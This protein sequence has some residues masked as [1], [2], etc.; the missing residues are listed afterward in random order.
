MGQPPAQGLEEP[1][2][3]RHAK[4]TAP[5]PAIV[6]LAVGPGHDIRG[7]CWTPD[8]LRAEGNLGLAGWPARA[9]E[10]G[11]RRSAAR[12]CAPDRAARIAG[13]NGAA[14]RAVEAAAPAQ[15]RGTGL[16]SG[17]FGVLA[18]LCPLA[19]GV[20]AEEVGPASHD[21]RDSRRDMGGAQLGA[22]CRGWAG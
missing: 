10:R 14:L 3:P 15:L 18:R 5:A 1:L 19:A 8:R 12:R 16:S 17:R 20:V 11:V 4:S 6:N 13:G 9:G 7:L 22:D 2:S 21:K